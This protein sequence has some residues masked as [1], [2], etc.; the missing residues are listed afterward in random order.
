MDLVTVARCFRTSN[1]SSAFEN[2]VIAKKRSSRI[3]IFLQNLS[4]AKYLSL[5]TLLFIV[6]VRLS[7]ST[8]MKYVALDCK[9]WH[10]HK[11]FT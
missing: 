1:G 7:K 11:I 9:F 6:E 2:C 4:F 8:P 5:C 3:M 10:S